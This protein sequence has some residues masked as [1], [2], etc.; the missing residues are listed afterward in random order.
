MDQC[1]QLVARMQEVETGLQGFKKDA[2]HKDFRLK[3]KKN[4]NTKI[5]QISATWNRIRDCTTGLCETLSLYAQDADASKRQFAEY[6]MAE[7]L[8]DDAEVG[9][10]AQPRAAWPVAQVAVRV[11]ARFP[12]IEE[13]F[14]GFMYKACPYLVPDFAGSHLGR[15]GPAPG[16]RPEEP[17]TDFADRMVS[18]QRLRLA[19]LVTREDLGPVWQWLARTLNEPPAPITAPLLHAALEMAGADAQARYRRQF[20]KLVA[21]I[22]REYMK[23]LEALQGRVRGEEADQLRASSSRLRHW[24]DAF[25]ERGRAPPPGGRQIDVTEEAELNPDA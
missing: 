25:R 21:Y 11:F 8:A 14:W 23:E 1:A 10:K 20:V 4:L 17:F 22:D 24:L 6:A 9:I 18:Y 7:R 2:Q 19:L 15:R 13:L 12:E 3:V 5:S 16:Q